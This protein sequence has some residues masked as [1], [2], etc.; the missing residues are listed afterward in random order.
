MSHHAINHTPYNP[1]EQGYQYPMTGPDRADRYSG[2]QWGEISS[3]YRPSLGTGSL[4][5]CH[6]SQGT[7]DVNT[8]RNRLDGIGSDPAQ[9]LHQ[10]SSQVGPIR[11]QPQHHLPSSPLGYRSTRRTHGQSDLDISDVTYQSESLSSDN[12]SQRSA[13]SMRVI[14][15]QTLQSVQDRLQSMGDQYRLND[16]VVQWAQNLLDIPEQE[17][18]L[19]SILV[20]LNSRIPPAPSPHIREVLLRPNIKAYTRR[21]AERNHVENWPI[22]M[23]KGLIFGQSDAFKCMHLPPDYQQDVIFK[24]ELNSLLGTILKGEKNNF[25][26]LLRLGLG[27]ANPPIPRQSCL[28]LSVL[29]TKLWTLALNR[30]PVA[31]I[32]TDSRITIQR[33]ARLAYIRT[34]INLNRLRRIANPGQTAFPSFWDDIDADLETRR[35]KNTPTFNQMFRHLVIEKDH[36]LWDGT[37][38]ADDWAD[39]DVQLPTDAEVQARIA[40]E[41]GNPQSV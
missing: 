12:S 31:N 14:N 19:M 11:T 37:K 21:M 41:A 33:Q 20:N 26:N 1:G 2:S 16:E 39:L 38:I 24:K 29:F 40:Q 25:A 18:W 27:G 10:I 34:M 6:Q 8:D 30:P 7:S 3:D 28:T 9:Q 32:P 36:R 4:A 15:C 5:N 35:T 23:A 17:L 22:P 13:K